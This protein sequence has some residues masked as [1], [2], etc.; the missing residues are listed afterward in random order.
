MEYRLRGGDDQRITTPDARDDEVLLLET[1]SFED[2]LTEEGFVRE[3]QLGDVSIAGVL[4]LITLVA[5]RIKDI[6]GQY[7]EDHPDDTGEV[8]KGAASA[9]SATWRAPAER[10]RPA[11]CSVPLRASVYSSQRRP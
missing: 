10:E 4:L 5:L 3:L 7:G 2:G 6:E 9:R 8:G 1:Y 11:S